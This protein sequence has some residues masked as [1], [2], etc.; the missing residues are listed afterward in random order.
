MQASPIYSHTRTI[1]QP[2][3]SSA[4]PVNR[5]TLT[6]QAPSE[7]APGL[8]ALGNIPGRVHDLVQKIINSTLFTPQQ[9]AFAGQWE[10][11]FIQL[12]N[13]PNQVLAAKAV[14]F[15][16]MK[17]ITPALVRYAGNRLAGDELVPLMLAQRELLTLLLPENSNVEGFIIHCEDVYNLMLET[18]VIL[19]DITAMNQE[20]EQLLLQS[21]VN[22]RE[23]IL[24][25]ANQSREMLRE[26]AQ[27]WQSKIRSIAE[28]LN[29]AREKADCLNSKLQ[30]HA[31]ELEVH[32][33]QL[34]K[35][36]G[37]FQGVVDEL[38]TL[39]KK[40]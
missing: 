23:R 9:Q 6:L 20:T 40:V 31:H 37:V 16:G 1:Q 33:T 19:N 17:A 34:A 22:M 35:E 36:Q 2:A 30:T 21:A 38:K 13:H 5:L 25:N 12:L 18:T 28:K 3:E 7:T 11:H 14:C 32:G 27:Q 24:N 39:L 10:K 29:Q 8:S 4:Q 26:L 15:L